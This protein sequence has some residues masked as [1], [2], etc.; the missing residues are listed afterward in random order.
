MRNAPLSW[1]SR[2]TRA[3][4]VMALGIFL[5]LFAVFPRLLSFA[6]CGFHRLTGLPC[7]FCGGTRAARAILQGDF[8]LALYLNPLAFGVLIF[9]GVFCGIAVIEA[10]RGQSMADWQALWNRR[11]R[12]VL[13]LLVVGVLL[14]WPVHLF[15][16]L[17]KPKTELVNL[18]NPVALS[19]RV[20]LK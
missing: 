5:T 19:L 1:E 12:I 7:P 17:R 15:S 18:R 13:V 11:H 4:V 6:F 16:A 10:L 20:W 2:L 9:L 3:V 8:L 14:W